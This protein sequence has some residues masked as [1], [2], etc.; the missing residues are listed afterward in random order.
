[1]RK[2]TLISA[3]LCFAQTINMS[4]QDVYDRA[5]ALANEILKE[6]RIED[7]YNPYWSTILKGTQQARDWKLEMP[8]TQQPNQTSAQSAKIER[9]RTPNDVMLMRQRLRINYNNLRRSYEAINNS[10]MMNNLRNRMHREHLENAQRSAQDINESTI[11]SARRNVQQQIAQARDFQGST[12]SSDLIMQQRGFRGNYVDDTGDKANT[13]PQV[14]PLDGLRP[15]QRSI[16]EL[17]HQ[18][19]KDESGLSDE[20]FQRL[21]DYLEKEMSEL[22]NMRKQF[23]SQAVENDIDDET[24]IIIADTYFPDPAKTIK[25]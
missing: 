21:S 6:K 19:E 12:T 5:T 25:Q 13:S 22:G 11:G 8:K 15:V 10:P 18:Y 20:E 9:K 4:A 23:L 24:A 16:P 1:M 7:P 3:I 17:L 2:T 14:E